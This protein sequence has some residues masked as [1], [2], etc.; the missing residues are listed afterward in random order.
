MKSNVESKNNQ[1]NQKESDKMTLTEKMQHLQIQSQIA[2]QH[3]PIVKNLNE[4]SQ[5]VGYFMEMNGELTRGHFVYE[6]EEFSSS[7]T[8]KSRQ[9][10]IT[11]DGRFLCFSTTKEIYF[12][13][14]CNEEHYKLHRNISEK[15]YFSLRELFVV[16]N[17]LSRKLNQKPLFN[18]PPKL[19][20]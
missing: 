14:K 2:L 16:Y 10:F 20:E 8:V 19:N 17:T 7:N 18:N 6:S 13:Q 4:H 11:K 12:C 5:D 3:D 9:I 15:Q 1:T